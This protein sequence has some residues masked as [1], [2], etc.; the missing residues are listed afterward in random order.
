M[1]RATA[2]WPPVTIPDAASKKSALRQLAEP[3]DGIEDQLSP[4][5]HVTNTPAGYRSETLPTA[6]PFR[7][8]K[9][10]TRLSAGSDSRGTSSQRSPPSLVRSRTPLFLCV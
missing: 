8:S 2:P 1:T 3:V 4:P 10:R 7:G 6:Q 5:S 9:K